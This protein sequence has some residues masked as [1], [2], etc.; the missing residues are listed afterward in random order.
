MHRDLAEV[1]RGQAADGA[2]PEHW[3]GPPEMVDRLAEV[4]GVDAGDHVL[5]LGCGVGGPARRLQALT[6]CRVT[7]IDLLPD[8]VSEARRRSA[9]EGEPLPVAAAAATALP[10]APGSFDHAWA[11]GVVAHLGDLEAFGREAVRVLRPGGVLAVTEA[12]WEGQRRPR[13]QETA[14][15]PW[16]PLMVAELEEALLA[17]GLRVERRPWPG[18]GVP[19]A[20]DASDLA[21]RADLADGRLAPHLVLGRKA[22]S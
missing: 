16:R 10:F 7:G 15:R 20:L 21:L 12:F 6:G 11:L 22:G 17:V 13:F 1:Y 19:G 5:D 3:S 8:V 9:A 18:A 4:V 14:P 2:R